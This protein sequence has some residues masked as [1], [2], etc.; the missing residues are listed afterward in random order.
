[1][2]VRISFPAPKFITKLDKNITSR[3]SLNSLIVRRLNYSTFE[4]SNI[5]THCNGV[6]RNLLSYLNYICHDLCTSLTKNAI[7]IKDFSL[8]QLGLILLII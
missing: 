6:L 2:R 8:V 4:E 1:M 3:K 7:I 5:L